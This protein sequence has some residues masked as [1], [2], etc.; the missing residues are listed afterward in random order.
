MTTVEIL[1]AARELI[2]D[3]SRWTQ[4]WF[5]RDIDGER[6][7]YNSAKAACWCADGAILKCTDNAEYLSVNILDFMDYVI[8]NESGHKHACLGWYNDNHSHAEVL[9]IFDRAILLAEQVAA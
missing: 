5:A 3:P 6:T 8:C 4:R 1:R 9:A 2:S 7:T